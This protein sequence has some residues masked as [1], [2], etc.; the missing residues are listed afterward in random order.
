R[1]RDLEDVGDLDR[2]CLV[3]RTGGQPG[4]R[5]LRLHL[6]DLLVEAAR[7][8]ALRPDDEHVCD[9]GDDHDR[10]PDHGPDG[11]LLLHEAAPWRTEAVMAK[12]TPGLLSSSEAVANSSLTDWSS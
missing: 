1:L 8:G 3:L 9:G 6:G 5:H 10:E 4:R 7:L 11:D 12:F 2:R